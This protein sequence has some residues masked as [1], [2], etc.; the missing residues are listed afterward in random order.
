M[1]KS[2]QKRNCDELAKIKSEINELT[3]IMTSLYEER[4]VNQSNVNHLEM[5]I[6]TLDSRCTLLLK[7][8]KYVEGLV[9][10]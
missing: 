7:E 2:E 10:K 1:Y 6:S 5:E 8:K 3:K 4:K 9:M